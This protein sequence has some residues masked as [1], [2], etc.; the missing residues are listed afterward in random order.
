VKRCDSTASSIGNVC[1]RGRAGLGVLARRPPTLRSG[2]V[3]E[4]GQA[5]AARL[6][7]EP[8]VLHARVL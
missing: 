3:R 2:D 8:A 5:L 7:D 4:T 6:D 1:Q